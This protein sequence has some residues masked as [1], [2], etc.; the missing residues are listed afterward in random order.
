MVFEIAPVLLGVCVGAIA[1]LYA[2]P[3][4]YLGHPRRR[5]SSIAVAPIETSYALPAVQVEAPV[6]AAPA[7]AEPA[8][9]PAPALYETVQP[10]VPPAPVSYAPSSVASFGPSPVPRK[11]TR[12]Y[13]RRTAPVRSTSVSKSPHSTKTKKR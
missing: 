13:R 2:A 12:T 8:P 10:E 1:V 3:R 9:S 7:T 6:K 11:P 5:G 4:G